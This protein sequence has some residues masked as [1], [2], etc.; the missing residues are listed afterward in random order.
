MGHS[1]RT[2]RH[3]PLFLHAALF[4]VSFLFALNYIFSKLGMA[5]FNPMTFAFLRVAGSA[6]ILNL[7]L[8][9]RAAPPL[10]R[11]DWGNVVLYSVLGVVCNQM[12]FLIGL[13]LTS[14]HV[15]A[16][17]ITTVP[18]FALAA[19]IVLGRERASRAKIGGIALAAAG[20]LVLV[21]GEGFAGATQSLVGDLFII[22]NSFCYALYLVVSKPAMSRMSPRRVIARMFAIAAVILLPICAVPMAHQEWSIIPARAWLALALVIAGPTVAAYVIN[23]W[24]LAHVDSSLVATYIYVQPAIT[25]VLAAIFLGETIRAA[26]IAAAVMIFGGVWISGR[27]SPPAATEEAVPGAAD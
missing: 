6:V 19:A 20:A 9:D 16:I 21:G 11:R 4:S 26:G 13:S 27:P 10:P 5:A 8:H 12:F 25:I 14:A 18:M 22:L 15:A 1:A 3:S 7:F 17:L 23:A 2:T 24:T